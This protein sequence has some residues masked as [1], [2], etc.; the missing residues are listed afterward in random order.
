MAVESCRQAGIR[1]VM[2]TGDH[3]V[4][5]HTIAQTL[6]IA[7]D[8]D[9]TVDGRELEVMDDDELA[10]RIQG[11]AVFARVHPAQKLRIVAA[12]QKRG[13][14]VAMTG[15]GV[16]DAPALV[17]ADVGI[18]MGITGT[19]VAK[20]SAKIVIADDNFTTIV[21]AVEEGRVVYR[22]I[23]KVVLY[24]LSTSVAH[25]LVLFLALVLGYPPPLAA[26]QI[27]WINLVTEG[28]VTVT[29]IME[30]AEG[31]EMRSKPISPREP[32]LTR[33]LLSRMAF[34]TPAMAAS[35]LGWFVYLLERGVS[36]AEARTEAF[37][38]MAVCCWF[39]VLNCRSER[40]SALSLGLV[41][42]PWL[43]GGLAVSQALH[44]A[45]VFV[46]FIR[47]VFHTV[48]R[49]LRDAVGIGVVAS[50]VLWVEELRKLLWRIHHR[51]RRRAT[52]YG[53]S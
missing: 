10:R 20:E 36:V 21:S 15:D 17:K 22:N 14:V 50:L 53:A 49:D 18:A 33:M 38:V 51:R 12:Y 30:P 5:G 6:A 2:V 35:T 1:A 16:N 42:N 32:L 39:N 23:K 47:D 37:T 45:V 26:V 24:L 7:R 31:D 40:H 43:L 41:K 29:L 44:A 4:T 28:T 11:I 8:G 9:E 48:P 27:L 25:V 13:E 19:E 34:M 46:P 3:R 52:A